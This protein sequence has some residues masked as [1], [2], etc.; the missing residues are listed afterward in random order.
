[1]TDSCN[2]PQHFG[3][4][5]SH[6]LQHRGLRYLKWK[7]RGRAFIWTQNIK[8]V[9]SEIAFKSSQW[10]RKSHSPG[11]WKICIA[12]QHCDWVD[13]SQHSKQTRRYPTSPRKVHSVCPY[14]HTMPPA[15]TLF[16]QHTT[17]QWRKVISFN[18]HNLRDGEWGGWGEHLWC[19]MRFPS[20]SDWAMG[21]GFASLPDLGVKTRERGRERDSERERLWERE[22]ERERRTRKRRCRRSTDLCSTA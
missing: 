1:M 18:T 17:T 20:L 14:H 16:Y 5:H 22:R 15:A 21:S 6:F 12:T 11:I 9:I 7:R 4:S 8:I 13:G 19:V 2:W 10:H 3:L